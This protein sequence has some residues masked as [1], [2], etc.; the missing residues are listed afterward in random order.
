MAANGTAYEERVWEAIA[1]IPAGKVRT[2]G[3]IAAQ[4]GNGAVAG[5]GPV[6]GTAKPEGFGFE[7]VDQGQAQ[8]AI[9]VG[10]KRGGP[11][12]GHRVGGQAVLRVVES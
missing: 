12:F 10:G 6:I 11:G 8:L 2:Y 1:A 7:F 3:E 4:V 5:R 9:R